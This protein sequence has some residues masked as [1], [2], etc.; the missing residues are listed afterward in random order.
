MKESHVVVAL[1]AIFA[2]HCG[3][4]NLSN[5]PEFSTE[6]EVSWKESLVRRSWDRCNMGLKGRRTLK[7]AIQEESIG[8][9]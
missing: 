2:R 1:P 4:S 9:K 3:S 6:Y 8:L 7:I 5:R